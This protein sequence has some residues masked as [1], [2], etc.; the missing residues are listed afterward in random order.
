MGTP[1]S[2]AEDWPLWKNAALLLQT[3]VSLAKRLQTDSEDIESLRQSLICFED[4]NVTAPIL[5]VH[6]VQATEIRQIIGKNKVLV[7]FYTGLLFAH[8]VCDGATL[9]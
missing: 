3:K 5:P 4:A 8:N 1:R 9:Y 6:E 7:S 2:T